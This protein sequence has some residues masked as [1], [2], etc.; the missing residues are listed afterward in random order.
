[1]AKFFLGKVFGLLIFLSGCSGNLL[2]NGEI[3]PNR[4]DFVIKKTQAIRHLKLKKE[5]PIKLV[6]KEEMKAFFEKEF[7]NDYPAEKL[8]H[9]EKAYKKLGVLEPEENLFELLTSFKSE[10]VVGIYDDEEKEIHLLKN[11]KSPG[12]TINLVQALSNHDSITDMILAHELTHG[13]QD[14]HFDLKRITD[15]C[16]DNDDL[17]LATSALIEGDA[18]YA[19]Q[20]MLNPLLI[21]DRRKLGYLEIP[22]AFL[23]EEMMRTAPRFLVVPFIFQYLYGAGFIVQLAKSSIDP[24]EESSFDRINQAF[25]D[26]PQSTEQIIDPKKYLFQRD[27]PTPV[28]LEAL[29]QKL[30]SYTLLHENTM[31]QLLMGVWISDIL[32]LAT[33]YQASDGW[34]GDRYMVLEDPQSKRLVFVQFSIWDGEIDA[35]QYANAYSQMV[36]K[37]TPSF[38][39]THQESDIEME[40]TDSQQKIYLLRTQNKVAILDGITAQE[41]ESIKKLLRAELYRIQQQS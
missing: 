32:S 27:N 16:K 33:G 14:Q 38:K 20:S 8:Q 31:G 34:D 24:R 1:M 26:L 22:D 39:Q 37:K 12:I 15:L 36:S 7:Q 23:E 17:D 40:W 3:D 35:I 21:P 19:S 28:S 41:L 11:P 2:K 18:D 5:I 29:K 13:L 6:S 10:E 4:A 9:L 30:S 25:K